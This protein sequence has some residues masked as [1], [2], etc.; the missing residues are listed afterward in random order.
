MN[1]EATEDNIVLRPIMSSGVTAGGVM[2]PQGK[3]FEDGAEII[4]VGPDVKRL[5][6]GD[7]VVRPDPCHYTLKDDDTGEI[8]LICSEIDI[9][10]K[11]LPEIPNA[12]C[13][14]DEE[15][16]AKEAAGSKEG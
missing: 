8:L 1:L 12:T 15:K 4:S 11:I 3:T 6:I 5:A 7:I 2:L 13:T 16:E 14:Q 9:M 10:A